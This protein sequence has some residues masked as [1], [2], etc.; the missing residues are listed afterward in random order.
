MQN[1][2][3]DTQPVSWTE[4]N[5]AIMRN[6]HRN[7]CLD[8]ISAVPTI[9]NTA[10]AV[11]WMAKDWTYMA[12]GIRAHPITVALLATDPLYEI[13]A[14]NT[15]MTIEKEAST[16]LLNEF[17]TLYAN[18]NGRGRG[19]VKT[20]MNSELNLWAGGGTDQ[21]FQWTGL[22]ENRKILSA[23]MDIVC[24]KYCVRIAVWW[25][26]HKKLSVWP[27]NEPD[28]QSWASAPILNIEVLSSGEAHIIES[29][30]LRVRANEWVELFTTIGEWQWTRPLTWPSISAK[31]LKDLKA[32]YAE[33]AGEQLAEQLPKKIDKDTLANLIYRY[34]WIDIRLTSKESSFY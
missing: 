24:V 12:S 16:E 26:E 28:D 4:I 32:D 34:Q 5:E 21:P 13:S 19:W 17:D 25:S 6:P 14:P 8:P 9:S 29:K 3:R 23:L 20:Q 27:I 33:V 2:V 18:H 31:T 30:D 1:T 11:P 15:R 10:A 7:R 22:L